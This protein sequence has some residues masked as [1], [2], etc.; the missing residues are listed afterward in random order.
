MWRCYL[1][2]RVGLD[3]VEERGGWQ[4]VRHDNDN[5]RMIDRMIARATNMKMIASV[6]FF[7]LLSMSSFSPK[8]TTTRRLPSTPSASIARG[9]T[10]RSAASPRVPSPLNSAASRRISTNTTLPSSLSPEANETLLASLKQET[11]QKEQVATRF[12]SLL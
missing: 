4:S 11:D 9:A 2:E 1:R 8:T 10:A 6:F 12:Q 7:C 3:I 5:D